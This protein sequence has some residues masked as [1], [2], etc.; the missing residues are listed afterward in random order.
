MASSITIVEIM[1]SPIV[2]KTLAQKSN[3]LMRGRA[4][5]DP[6]APPLGE[7]R[8]TKASPEINNETDAIILGVAKLFRISLRKDI[9]STIRTR[10]IR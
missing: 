5:I 1:M 7:R 4:M 6:T 8:L 3:K 10:G 2:K 9:P